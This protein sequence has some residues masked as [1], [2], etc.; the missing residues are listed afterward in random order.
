MVVSYVAFSGEVD[1][2]F[3][4]ENASNRLEPIAGIRG[5][6]RQHEEAEP[7]GEHDKVQH[8]KLLAISVFELHTRPPFPRGY[9]DVHQPRTR[10][11][12]PSE[13][14]LPATR[15]VGFRDGSDGDFIGIS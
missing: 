2:R 4:V 6:N 13:P 12:L 5:A 11:L 10:L 9:L 14:P 3:A 1:F 7:D 15:G 8:E